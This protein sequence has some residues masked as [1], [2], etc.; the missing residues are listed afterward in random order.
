MVGIPPASARNRI[1]FLARR[2]AASTVGMRSSR[3]IT[4]LGMRWRPLADG[5]AGVD[6]CNRIPSSVFVEVFPAPRPEAVWMSI[7]PPDLN[8]PHRRQRLT[9]DRLRLRLEILVLHRGHGS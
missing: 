6:D 7:I 9:D 5:V 3:T 1:T 8:G 2:S 4:S